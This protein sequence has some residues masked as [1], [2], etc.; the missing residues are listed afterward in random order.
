ME[1]LRGE[2]RRGD[3]SFTP[4]GAAPRPPAPDP[5]L[6]SPAAVRIRGVE[7]TDA[8]VPGA[9]HDRERLALRNPLAEEL[10]G[11]TDAAEVAPPERDAR[12]GLSGGCIRVSSL[13]TSHSLSKN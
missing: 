4:P 7:P 3:V 10:R 2:H 6:A 5:R 11:R 9:L 8:G 13:R 12:E 1:D